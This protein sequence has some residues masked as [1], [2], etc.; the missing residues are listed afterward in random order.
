MVG[1]LRAL[2]YTYFVA[3]ASI[4]FLTTIIFATQ[5]VPPVEPQQNF[6]CYEL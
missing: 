6:F 3:W 1:Y 5:P 4:C 2:A